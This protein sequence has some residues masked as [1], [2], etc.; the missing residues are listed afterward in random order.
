MAPPV[1]GEIGELRFEQLHGGESGVARRRHVGRI[2]QDQRI[3]AAAD[4]DRMLHRGAAGHGMKDA[5][6]FARTEPRV[7]S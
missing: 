6:A 4:L 7:G 2:E 3:E 1:G 5:G